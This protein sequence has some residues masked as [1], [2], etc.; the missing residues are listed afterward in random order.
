MAMHNFFEKNPGWGIPA[1]KNRCFL[2]NPANVELFR[3]HTG[4]GASMQFPGS[5]PENLVKMARNTVNTSELLML[6]AMS[7]YESYRR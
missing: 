7:M 5:N 6:K 2:P 4:I 1:E 3:E